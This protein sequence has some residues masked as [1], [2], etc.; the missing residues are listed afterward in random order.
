MFWVLHISN[1]KIVYET[2]NNMFYLFCSQLCVKCGLCWGDICTIWTIDA[3]SVGLK[4]I[5]CSSLVIVLY[6]DGWP[7]SG[8]CRWRLVGGGPSVSLRNTLEQSCTQ[9]R[10]ERK[11]GLVDL[12]PKSK[13]VNWKLPFLTLKYHTSP[14]SSCYHGLYQILMSNSESLIHRRNE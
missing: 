12:P 7:R 3:A 8:D 2:A 5:T 1:T 11:M 10:N 14:K 6:R 9:H 13:V 4:T